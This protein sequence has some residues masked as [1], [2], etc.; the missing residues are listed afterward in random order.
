MITIIPDDINIKIGEYKIYTF[1]PFN[2]YI[3]VYWTV[4]GEKRCRE[5]KTG[6]ILTGV[7]TDFKLITLP[8]KEMKYWQQFVKLLDM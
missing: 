5:L 6:E 7:F 1:S 3:I 2:R 4:D 8:N